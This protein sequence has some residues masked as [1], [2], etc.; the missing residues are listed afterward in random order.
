MVDM[1]IGRSRA[2]SDRNTEPVWTESQCREYEQQWF[3]DKVEYQGFAAE[4]DMTASTAGGNETEL[5]SSENTVDR[6]RF[7][8]DEGSSSSAVLLLSG[9][10]DR[11]E[12]PKREKDHNLTMRSTRSRTISVPDL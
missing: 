1:E 2:R 12:K 9:D 7:Q 4:Y 10:S 5:Y 11:T 6:K 3:P 8:Y